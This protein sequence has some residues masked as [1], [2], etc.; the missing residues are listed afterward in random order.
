MWYSGRQVGL[1]G[2]TPSG[3]QERVRG[4]RHSGRQVGLVGGSLVSDGRIGRSVMIWCIEGVEQGR[5]G[6]R[7]GSSGSLPLMGCPMPSLSG[8]VWCEY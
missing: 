2:W 8:D 5:G 6:S 4:D 1:V 3:S 7:A